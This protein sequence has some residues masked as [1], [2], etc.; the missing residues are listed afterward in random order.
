MLGRLASNVSNT[1]VGEESGGR[2]RDLPQTRIAHLSPSL[3]FSA[4]DDYAC[5]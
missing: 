2:R 3:A 4:A 1:L 5:P